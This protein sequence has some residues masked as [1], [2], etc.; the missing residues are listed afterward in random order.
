MALTIKIGPKGTVDQKDVTAN[1]DFRTIM[2]EGHQE[3]K[4]D[5][6]SFSMNVESNEIPPPLAGQEVI[7]ADGATNEFGGSIMVVDRRQGEGRFRVRYDIECVDY[8]YLL[9]R[10]HINKVYAEATVGSIM[11]EMLDD[12]LTD[13]GND[14]VVSID[15]HYTDFASASGKSLIKT[16]PTI[17]EQ[18][19]ERML[20][21]QAFDL[22]SAAA[23]MEWKINA[24]KQIVLFDVADNPA[25]PLPLED[26]ERILNVETN[27]DDFHDLVISEDISTIGTRVVVRDALIK[28]TSTEVETFEAEAVPP[29]S[30]VELGQNRTWFQLSKRPFSFLD[31]TEVTL[32]EGIG[33]IVQNL[34]KDGV[35]RDR[36]DDSSSSGDCFIYVGPA[37]SDGPSYVRFPSGDIKATDVVVVT[38]NYI[39]VDDHFGDD[40]TDRQAIIDRTGGDGVHEFVF[41]QANEIMVTDRLKLDDLTDLI[42]ARKREILRTGTFSSFSK[43]WNAGGQFIFQWPAEALEFEAFI[44][45]V[46]KTVRSPADDAAF[47][48]DSIIETLVTFSNIPHGVRV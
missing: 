21:S 23:G 35:E 28:S 45:S 2:F 40:D 32:D 46:R 24:D 48:S 12:L 6:L 18:R 4:G 14:A 9:D 11:K 29:T 31:I 19:I 26:D 25:T 41:S 7:F 8:I 3:I 17:K 47:G 22:I 1:V 43:G 33:A 36:N 30:G 15:Q 10:R 34:K 27:V 39:D 44:I 13:A 38:Y 37:N 16:G 5:I 20:P 42:F